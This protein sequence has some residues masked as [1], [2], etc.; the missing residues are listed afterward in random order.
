M[1]QINLCRVNSTGE[2]LEFSVECGSKYYFDSIVVTNLIENKIYDISNILK[3]SE[4][5]NKQLSRVVSRVPTK[6]LQSA[7]SM[8]KVVFTVAKFNETEPDDKCDSSLTQVAYC[9][10]VSSIYKHLIGTLLPLICGRCLTEIPVEI[11]R[12]F[13][14]LYAH[15]LAMKHGQD[16]DAED[17]FKL[18]RNHYQSCDNGDCSTYVRLSGPSC[19]CH[20]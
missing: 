8:F 13:T 1:I 3:D 9:S 14:L 17:F 11:Q 2:Y 20:K 10:D 6:F 7:P 15:I 5:S 4:Y 19:G 12:V 16:A 18:L